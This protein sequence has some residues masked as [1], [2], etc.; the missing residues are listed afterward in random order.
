[1]DWNEKLDGFTLESLLDA[2]KRIVTKEPRN[3]FRE[4]YN[5]LRADLELEAIAFKANFR[6]YLRQHKTFPENFSIGLDFTGTLGETHLIR[7]NGAHKRIDDPI[8][9]HFYTFHIH[10]ETGE[11]DSMNKLR[12]IENTT[13]YSDFSS[14]LSYAFD[15]LHIINASEYFPEVWQMTLA[16]E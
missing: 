12:S 9:D 2:E 6:M 13:E 15:R 11:K 4:E 10:I 5:H 14:A 16:L 8:D 3:G 1:M 7:F